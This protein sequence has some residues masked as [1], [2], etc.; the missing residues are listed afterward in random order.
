M[1]ELI[2]LDP[3]LE[4]LLREVAAAPGS[5]GRLPRSAEVP[6]WLAS[7]R[8]SSTSESG[9]LLAEREL[10]RV[11][12]HEIAWILRQ[13]AL[14]ELIDGERTREEVMRGRTIDAENRP[15]DRSE[16][17]VECASVRVASNADLNAFQLVSEWLRGDSSEGPTAAALAG[18]S[19][20]F[21]PTA[22]ARAIAGSDFS[23]R[24]QLASAEEWL[25]ASLQSDSTSERSVPAWNN[26]SVAL[27][28]Q[29]RHSQALAANR[30]AMAIDPDSFMSRAGIV[31]CAALMEDEALVR[32]AAC[33]LDHLQQGNEGAFRVYLRAIRYQRQR[34]RLVIPSAVTSLAERNAGD[35]SGAGRILHALT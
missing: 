2:R 18:A 21:V 24:G 31:L 27:L 34:G 9:L 16:I 11:G 22:Q 13:A 19:M 1:A 28:R 6:R 32:N 8:P 29:G 35:F 7:E 20:R 15:L 12:R 26:L 33:D 3:G 5:L 10:L 17:E 25:L 30:R 14:R 23:L 4:A